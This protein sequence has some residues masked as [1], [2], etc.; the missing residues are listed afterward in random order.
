MKLSK[1]IQSVPGSATI[2]ITAQ[3][4]QMQAQGID[5]VSFAA[6]EPDFDT[7]TFIKEA[8]EAAMDAG[9]TKYTPRAA[10]QLR[11][12]ISEKLSRE[13]ALNVPAEQ[14]VATFGTKHGLY[15][16]CQAVLDPGDAALIPSPYWVSYPEMV[17]LAGG[18]PVAL[19]TDPKAGFKIKPEQ[20]TEA[21]DDAK[22]LFLNS[23]C[24]PTGATYTAEELAGVARAVMRT[25]MLVFSDEIYE[26]LIYGATRT[27]SIGALEEQAPGI[28]ERTVTF[29]GPAKAFAMTG[30]RIGWAAGPKKIID[31]IARLKSHETT[32]P[33]SFVQAAA[34]AA[35]T[36]EDAAETIEQ[37]RQE[38]EKRGRHMTERLNGIKDVQ[39]VQPDGAFYCFPDVSAHYGRRIGSSEVSDS[40]EF[41][42]A[43]LHEANVAVIPGKPFGEDRCVRLSFATGMEQIDKGLDRLEKLLT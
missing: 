40:V 5:V 16:A 34:L 24:N 1:R 14:I 27:V 17:K 43:L 15:A 11:V 38:F 22:V 12:A 13:N 29:N 35:Y 36:H 26:K 6:G 25:D 41:A 20:I 10:S 2:A 23:P 9:D 18:R 37:M 30:W 4:E 42:R 33:V 31:A 28:G 3:A 8:G 21:A 32:H 39:C 7:P 19:P